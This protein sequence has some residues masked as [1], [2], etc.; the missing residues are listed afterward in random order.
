M[1]MIPEAR[2]EV[3]HIPTAYRSLAVCWLTPDRPESDVVSNLWPWV[4]DPGVG[5]DDRGAELAAGAL[6]VPVCRQLRR[7]KWNR[8]RSVPS[9][10]VSLTVEKRSFMAARKLSML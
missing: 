8:V 9:M 6:A 3:L 5:R 1:A 2:Q 7:A 4:D 10:G